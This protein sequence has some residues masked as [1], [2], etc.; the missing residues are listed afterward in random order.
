MSEAA[1]AR[2]TNFVAADWLMRKLNSLDYE[3]TSATEH[4]VRRAIYDNY[5]EQMFAGLKDGRPETFAQ[6]FE[7]AFGVPL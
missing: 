3:C 4:A 7:R 5:C 6:I 2:E 1:A